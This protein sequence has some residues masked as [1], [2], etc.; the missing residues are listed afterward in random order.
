MSDRK[1]TEEAVRVG[2][3]RI[4]LGVQSARL[5][6]WDWNIQTGELVWSRE[7]LEMFGV[8]LETPM[9]YER[10]LEAVH[11]DDR[12]RIDQ[13]VRVALE[14]GNEYSTEMRTVWPEGSV[15]W[16]ASRG[17]AYYDQAR[18]PIRM[19]G[20]CMDIT[21]SKET[22]ENLLRARAEAKG[23]AE[24][25][26]AILDAVPAVTCIA[27]DRECRMMTASRAAYEMLRLPYGSNISKSA[28]EGER[29]DYKV[30]IDGRELSPQQM[31]VQQAALTGCSVSG[32]ELEVRF[33]DG[34][35]NYLFGHAVPLFDDGGRVRGAVGAFLDITD[36][37]VIEERL[38]AVTERFQVALRGTPVTVFSQDLDLRYKWVYNPVGRHGV[39]DLLGK[40]DSEILESAEDAALLEGLKRDVLRTG[41]SYQGDVA[42]TMSGVRRYYHVNIDPQRDTQGH[43]VGLTCASFDLTDRKCAEGA[44]RESEARHRQLAE[45]LDREVQSRTRELEEQT[46]QVTLA[47]DGLKELSARLLQIQDEERRRI[48]R[49]L[50]DSAGQVL[51]ALD[52]ELAHLGEEIRRTAPQ[53]ESRIEPAMRLVQQL[54]G[55]IRTTSHL[56]HPPLL[57][58]AGLFSAI[59]WYVEGMRER[60]GLDIHSEISP[61]FGRLPRDLELVVFRLVQESLTNIYRHSGSENGNIR[62]TREDGSVVVE[63]QDAGRG[64]SPEKLTAIQSGGSG[65]GIRG[66]RER[67]RQFHGELRVESGKSG[68]KVFATIP[69]PKSVATDEGAIEA[70]AS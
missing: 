52:L 13:A 47:S 16:I 39:A 29:P 26:A 38:R 6:V 4:S 49:D 41:Q 9:S 45:N 25:L 23:Q 19:S 17:R 66:M 5:G 20:A 58:E 64:M 40:R 67:L 51:T 27:H 62:I 65:V 69:I 57:D 22:E 33:A 31:P 55:E 32:K 2:D 44:L 15:R 43:I 56:L 54:Y 68:T 59:Q 30:L 61:D 37:K 14:T 1:Y 46:L 3:D 28:P 11:P 12:E 35:S 50:H 7:C 18:K 21:Q 34:S 10:F 70:R 48:A 60:S 63:V 53:L 24:N 8:A 42:V 36:R